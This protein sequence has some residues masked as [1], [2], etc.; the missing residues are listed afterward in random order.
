LLSFFN[1][2]LSKLNIDMLF[3]TIE[4]LNLIIPY[5]GQTAL[6]QDRAANSSPRCFQQPARDLCDGGLS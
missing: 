4:F 5:Y 3:Q 2:Y 6:S 1:F